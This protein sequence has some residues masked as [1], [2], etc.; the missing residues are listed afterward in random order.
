MSSDASN[1]LVRMIC[2][3]QKSQKVHKEIGEIIGVATT[4]FTSN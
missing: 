3:C 2:G 1:S 4:I